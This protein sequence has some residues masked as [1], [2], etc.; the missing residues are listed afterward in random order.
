M[1]LIWKLFLHTQ[2]QTYYQHIIFN[3]KGKKWTKIT[4][5]WEKNKHT[6]NIIFFVKTLQTLTFCLQWNSNMQDNTKV[7]IISTIE[8]KKNMM[9]INDQQQHN[10]Q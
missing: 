1:F 4:K 2:I 3:V 7:E 8:R 9:N 5:V 6:W 10:E